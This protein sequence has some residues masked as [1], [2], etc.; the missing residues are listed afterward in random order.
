LLRNDVNTFNKK[1]LH[2]NWLL[3]AGYEILVAGCWLLVDRR[4][5][6]EPLLAVI[7]I[8]YYGGVG[9]LFF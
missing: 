7:A 6:K 4:W 5:K 3:D 1:L 9:S 2:E 8:G